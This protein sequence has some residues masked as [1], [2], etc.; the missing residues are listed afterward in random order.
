VPNVW[1]I[2]PRRSQ[3]FTDSAARLEEVAPTG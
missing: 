3:A 2:D 1:L